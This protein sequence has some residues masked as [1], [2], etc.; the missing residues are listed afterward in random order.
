MHQF[1]CFNV[2][3]AGLLEQLDQTTTT[4]MKQM[5]VFITISYCFSAAETS[6]TVADKCVFYS[7]DTCYLRHK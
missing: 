1:G 6:I 2:F 7:G 4:L 5:S 3:V